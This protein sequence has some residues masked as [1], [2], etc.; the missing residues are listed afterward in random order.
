M[1]D[2][3]PYQPGHYAIKLL[4][5]DPWDIARFGPYDCFYV[6]GCQFTHQPEDIAVIGPRVEM[7]AS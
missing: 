4:P 1:S 7:P 6:P 3:Q 2:P 5:G